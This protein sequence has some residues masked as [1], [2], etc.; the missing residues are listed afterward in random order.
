MKTI[1]VTIDGGEK[2]TIS[3]SSERD[4]VTEMA[5]H[6]FRKVLEQDLLMIKMDKDGSLVYMTTVQEGQ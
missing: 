5:V 1:E 3:I 2:R 6:M 4:D